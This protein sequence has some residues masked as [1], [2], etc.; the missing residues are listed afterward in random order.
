MYSSVIH[1]GNYLLLCF[2][3]NLDFHSSVFLTP[4]L[5]IIGCHRHG[6]ANP[7]TSIRLSATPRWTSKIFTE[8][9]RR[10]ERSVLYSFD[11]TLSVRPSTLTKVF[12]YWFRTLATLFISAW[13]PGL[14]A[15][16]LLTNVTSPLN[17]TARRLPSLETAAA[18]DKAKA[19]SITNRFTERVDLTWLKRASIY[20]TLLK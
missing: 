15:L 3:G 7:T 12:G 11:P 8:V 4:G 9:A 5:G 16:E 10:I 17:V 20:L 13:S 14:T 6:F 1:N 18:S 19:L 2:R